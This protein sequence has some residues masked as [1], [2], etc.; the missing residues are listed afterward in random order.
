MEETDLFVKD[1]IDRFRRSRKPKDLVMTKS[2]LE[3][4]PIEPKTKKTLLE[5]GKRLQA[6]QDKAEKQYEEKLQTIRRKGIELMKRYRTDK[7]LKKDE[8]IM[9]PSDVIGVGKTGSKEE[10]KPDIKNKHL[11]YAKK[12]GIPFETDGYRRTYE[13][14]LKA[15]RRFEEAN[16]YD[17]MRKG[18]DKRTKEYGMFIQ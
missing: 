8:K 14:L 16:I 4:E 6:E 7:D 12:Y 5:I 15:I 10:D 9:R 17:I 2:L 18:L 11:H 13:D 3:R 1:E